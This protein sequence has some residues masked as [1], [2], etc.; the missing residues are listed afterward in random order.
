MKR[1]FITIF[2]VFSFCW[3]AEILTPWT[4]IVEP[5]IGGR[6]GWSIAAGDFNGDSLRDV[7][8]GA[9]FSNANGYR[10]GAV[11]VYFAPD[12]SIPSLIIPGLHIEDQ[13]G[14]SMDNAGDFDGDGFDDL[15]VG[16]N[17]VN[18]IGAAYIFYGGPSF[19]SIPDIGFDGENYVDNFG[20]SCAGIGDLNGDGFDDII[21]GALY[22]DALGDRT[23]KAYIHF[24]SSSPDTMPDILLIG[25]DINDDF[26]VDLDGRLDFDNDDIPDIL[27]G[28]VQAGD[29]FVKTG[30]A[31]V[32]TGDRLLLGAT[33]PEFKFHGEFPFN[34]FGGTVAALGDINGDGFDD[35]ISGAYNYANPL[36]TDT[37]VGRAYV[38][39]G[40]AG[41][42][43]PFEIPDII[44]TGRTN[45][46]YLA[47]TVG[48]P[49]DVDGDGFSD[50]AVSADWDSISG[51]FPGNV[52][53][54]CGGFTPDTIPDYI[55]RP[56]TGDESFGWS[57]EGLGDIT[58]DGFP[59]FAVSNGVYDDTGRVY[60]YAGFSTIVP[61]EA[62]IIMPF[63]SAISSDSMQSTSFLVIT[64]HIIDD[65]TVFITIG[66][67]TIG[68]D[69][70]EL[71]IYGDTITFSPDI[72]Y[73]DGDSVRICLVAVR[74]TAGDYLD[75]VVCT[76]FIIDLTSPVLL[77]SVP[78]NDDTVRYR[79]QVCAWLL[80]DSISGRIGGI[81]VVSVDGEIYPTDTQGY[82]N[83]K[84]V[85][86]IPESTGFASPRIPYRICLS[87][88]CDIPDY[89]EPNCSDDF[90]ETIT[91]SRQWIF[92]FTAQVSSK[93]PIDFYIGQSGSATDAYDPAVD[94]LMPPPIP[95]QSDVR[96][97]NDG[98]WLYRDMRPE[99]AESS[100]WIVKNLDTAQTQI[101]WDN[102]LLPSGIFLWNDKIDMATS[103]LAII[104]ANDSA[105][106]VSKFG[107]PEIFVF[108]IPQRWSLMGFPGYSAFD[109]VDD[110]TKL[111]VI[112]P[113]AHNETGYILLEKWL[114]CRGFFLFGLNRAILPVWTYSANRNTQIIN[115]M[116]NL[117][118]PPMDSVNISTEPD[119]IF[120]AP[121]FELDG[122]YYIPAS[123]LE[124]GKGYWF[125]FTDY[126]E[127][128]FGE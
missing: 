25:L 17:V 92:G 34:F 8:I 9:P 60:I 81:P 30:E 83:Y 20:F 70:D 72:A 56:L 74:T 128:I 43:S 37:S 29:P 66:S 78:D 111:D 75:S 42:S 41:T 90:C 110:L 40:R 94:I 26:S 35:V 7:A 99:L 84:L 46:D 103:D 27:I 114:G 32:F 77:L 119:S 127:V 87:G 65:S 47:G 61:I 113:L 82:A 49:G 125:F 97:Y 100:V 76:D 15:L 122:E 95:S 10:S 50:F 11:Y 31:Y 85:W 53:I 44:I 118:A 1:Y 116:W 16:A 79:P 62:E 101:H 80:I 18:D 93:E 21:I 109:N 91:F 57:I 104:D 12:F 63:D 105:V 88:I 108:E 4:I 120:L 55:C 123:V 86:T 117:L 14:I 126:G 71:T 13:F 89:G 48:A 58:G 96:I 24:G 45:Y 115:R 33:I 39:F 6:F 107:I 73:S 28:A 59:D 54:F 22:N 124:K 36:E 112:G 3:S 51:D 19:D 5:G 67:D 69:Y 64:D 2:A 106:I 52:L 23:G 98:L 121:P 102:R 38:Y 68:I